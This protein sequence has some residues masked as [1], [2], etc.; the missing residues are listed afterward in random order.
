MWEADNT[1]QLTK[2]DPGGRGWDW[3]D[4]RVRGSWGWQFLSWVEVHHFFTLRTAFLTT[5]KWIIHLSSMRNWQ[6][7]HSLFKEFPSR[8]PSCRLHNSRRA[9]FTPQSMWTAPLSIEQCMRCTTVLG[10]LVT[11]MTVLF[12]P[13]ATSQ[14]IPQGPYLPAVHGGPALASLQRGWPGWSSLRQDRSL[15]LWLSAGF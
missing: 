13:L 3:E 9:L 10:S 11:L 2:I 5:W 15:L 7:S 14:L 8:R 1:P 4:L 6:N 12:M